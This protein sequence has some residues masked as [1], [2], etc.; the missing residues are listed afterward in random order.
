M[1]PKIDIVGTLAGFGVIIIGRLEIMSCNS[2]DLPLGTLELKMFGRL[3]D[4][5]P[6]GK[7]SFVESDCFCVF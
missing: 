5:G 4:E 6:W 1:Q 7:I 3:K 2:N